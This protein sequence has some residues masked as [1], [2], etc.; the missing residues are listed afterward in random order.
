MKG[1]N[2]Q[3]RGKHNERAASGCDKSD[4]G[5]KGDRQQGKAKRPTTP[6]AVG[7]QAPNLTAPVSEPHVELHGVLETGGSDACAAKAVNKDG[8]ALS[9]SAKSSFMQ[10]M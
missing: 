8:K 3:K 7:L 6:A 10:K 5:E 2:R 9:G 1:E 4:V